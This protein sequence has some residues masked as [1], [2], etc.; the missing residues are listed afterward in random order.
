MQCGCGQMGC[1]DKS[2][3]GP[4]LG[5]LYRYIT[6]VSLG[7]KQHVLTSIEED[8]EHGARVFDQ[9]YTTV[10]KAMVTIIHTFDPDI[11]IVTGGLN[12]TPGLYD[13]VP[14]RW[15]KY[16]L[17]K[18]LTTKFVPATLGSLTGVKGAALMRD[19][20]ELR[21]EFSLTGN[22]FHAPAHP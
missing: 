8:L 11:I 19:K 3:S 10:A 7:N 1:I 20:I 22:P 2:I 4:S 9:F 17:S 16:A 14:K 18:T 6:G 15:G 12:K 5:R 13:E 21:K